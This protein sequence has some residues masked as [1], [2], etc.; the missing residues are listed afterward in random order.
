MIVET[1]VKLQ[2]CPFCGGNAVLERL[3]RGSKMLYIACERCHIKT[4]QQCS[5]EQIYSA[6][7][8]K[9]L[10]ETDVVSSLCSKWNRRAL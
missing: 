8:G 1:P 2:P 5:G 3:A 7:T 4:P 9:V 10:T 6:F